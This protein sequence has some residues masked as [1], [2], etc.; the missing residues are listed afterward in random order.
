MRCVT[1]CDLD[2]RVTARRRQAVE[3]LELVGE[4]VRCALGT[5]IV[6]IIVMATTLTNVSTSRPDSERGSS[7]IGG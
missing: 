3:Q 1:L 4:P 6:T 5:A 2:Q 7:V